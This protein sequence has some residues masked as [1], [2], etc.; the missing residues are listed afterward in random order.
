MYILGTHAGVVQRVKDHYNDLINLNTTAMLPTLY[1]KGVITLEDKD[2]ISLTKPLE[3][4]KMQ[5]LLDQIIMPSLQVGVIQKFKL[6][7]EVLKGSEDVVTRKVAQ[8]LGT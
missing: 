1:A 4:D 5:Y 3:R 6:L 2:T 7:V 8:Q